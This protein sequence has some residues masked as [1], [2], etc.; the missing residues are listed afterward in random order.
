MKCNELIAY[1]DN[2]LRVKEIKDASQNGLQ[3]EGLEEVIK[4]AFAVDA[5]QA[6]FEQAVAGEAQLLIVHHGLFWEEPLRLVGPHFRRVKTLIAG[7]CGL[8]AASKG[9]HFAW[10]LIVPIGFA[11]IAACWFYDGDYQKLFKWAGIVLTVIGMLVLAFLP[12]EHRWG[13]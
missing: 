9:C 6:A 8:Y 3:V 12:D 4:I 7:G 10:G 1:L 5:C 2:Y 11:C 13:V